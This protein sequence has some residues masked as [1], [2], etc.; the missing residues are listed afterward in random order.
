MK[1]KLHPAAG[2]L[3]G[4]LIAAFMLST[5]VVKHLI[6]APGLFI[7]IPALI[8][9]GASGFALARGGQGTLV[10][11]KRRRMPVIALNGLLVLVPCALTGRVRLAGQG[12]PHVR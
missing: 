10:D 1:K 3:A 2:S 7:L 12:I 4:L 5:L 9:T 6:V 11:A 8:A